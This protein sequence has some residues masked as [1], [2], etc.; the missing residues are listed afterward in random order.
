MVTSVASTTSMRKAPSWPAA[1]G[2]ALLLGCLLAAGSSAV[3]AEV[4]DASSFA[5]QAGR[6]GGTAAPGRLHHPV[7]V[8][9]PG[10]T[11]GKEWPQPN[12]CSDGLWFYDTNR[13]GE[14][15][16][17]ELR[18]FG[19]ERLVRCGTCHEEPPGGFTPESSQLPPRLN[20]ANSGLCIVCHKL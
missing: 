12:R 20:N 3:L 15:D 19:A 9:L 8:P 18:L 4:C 17:D 2:R 10:P 6:G 16:Q 1:A 14:L 11:A 5:A 13:N 7:E